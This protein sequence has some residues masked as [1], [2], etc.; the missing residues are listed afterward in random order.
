MINIKLAK[1]GWYRSKHKILNIAEA[2]GVECIVGCMLESQIAVTG[3][4]LQQRKNIVA[5]I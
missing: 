1:A 3:G 5:A 2:V 4:T